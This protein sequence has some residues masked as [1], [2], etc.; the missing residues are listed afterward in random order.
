[1]TISVS[2]GPISQYHRLTLNYSMHNIRI[3]IAKRIVPVSNQK[4]SEQVQLV[5][6]RFDNIESK[7]TPIWHKKNKTTFIW[8]IENGNDVY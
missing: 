4:N 5:K 2:F 1:M 3:G 7:M 6:Y 8:H